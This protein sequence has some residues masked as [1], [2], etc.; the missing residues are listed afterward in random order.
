M[1]NP[2]VYI[3]TGVVMA[4][5]A[6]IAIF[7]ASSN[8]PQATSHG[9]GGPGSGTKYRAPSPP[10]SPPPSSARRRERRRKSPERRSNSPA[11][12]ST[13]ANE[14]RVTCTNCGESPYIKI[15]P[16]NHESLCKGCFKT[17]LENNDTCPD[18]H[19]RID[20]CSPPIPPFGK[21]TSCRRFTN[22]LKFLDCNHS[23]SLCIRCF[24]EQNESHKVCP[25]CKQQIRGSEPSYTTSGI[26]GV[27]GEFAQFAR[28]QP[29]G[30]GNFCRR[31][32]SRYLESSGQEC[33]ECGRRVM[34]V[35]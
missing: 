7:A 29:C 21:C 10:P 30:H 12:V 25:K 13:S 23:L 33:S 2:A 19:G 20:S 17:H 22:L 31:H 11:L 34:D 1:T 15:S 28:F 18:C 8:K 26:C 6:V 5:A 35:V 4:V 14:Q 9:R 16:C 27:C 32:A 24:E 3:V